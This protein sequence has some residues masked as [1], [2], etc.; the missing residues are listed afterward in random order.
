[1]NEREGSSQSLES[2]KGSRRAWWRRL[3]RI[4]D[5]GDD[6]ESLLMARSKRQRQFIALHKKNRG[7]KDTHDDSPARRAEV[8]ED[9]GRGAGDVEEVAAR[10]VEDVERD[11]GAVAVDPGA[12]ERAVGGDGPE[13]GLDAVR[14]ARLVVEC[15]WGVGR[16]SGVG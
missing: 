14:V 16:G 4:G 3:L 10:D 11:L 15:V 1:M 12:G 8:V 7:T 5:D 2:G 9:R 6:L 13:G